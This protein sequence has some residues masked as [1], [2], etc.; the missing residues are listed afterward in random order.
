MTDQQV[1]RIGTR[2]EDGT[3]YAG[4]SPDT[5][6]AMYALAVDEAGELTFQEAQER[7]NVLSR[8]SGQSYRVPSAAELTVLFN[9]RSAI[10]GFDES[11]AYPRGYYRSAT[12]MND[13]PESVGASVMR[14]PHQEPFNIS[15]AYGVSVRLVR[16]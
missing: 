6:T 9:N 4:V 16:S 7:A 3:V 12:H 13:N 15:K 10:G 14:H 2:A 5:G 8:E 11:G 1:K